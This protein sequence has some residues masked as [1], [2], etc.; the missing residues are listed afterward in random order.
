MSCNGHST[1]EE[2]A[3]SERQLDVLSI[4]FHIP[5]P[6]LPEKKSADKENLSPLAVEYFAQEGKKKDGKL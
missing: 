4:V 2:T 3:F 5:Y 6:Y 1:Y